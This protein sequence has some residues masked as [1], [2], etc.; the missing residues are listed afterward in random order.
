MGFK[1]DTSFLRFLTMGALGVRRVSAELRQRGFDP[2][3]LERY[4]TSNKIWA[5]KVKRLR[6]PDLLCV[7]TGLRVEV[8]TKSDLKIRMSD[9]PNNPDRA[10]DAGCRNEDVVALIA[11][12][13][14]PNG[15]EP[16]DGAVYFSVRALRD[17]V[18][19]SK[20]GPPKSA[21][22]GAERDR[23][24]PATI[25]SRPGK[26]L[27]V[28]RDRLVVT[29]EGDG[30]PS[31]NQT[32]SL[33]D[34]HAYVRP[35]EKFAA[36]VTI[37][38]GT[39]ASLADLDGPLA[40]V[41][42]PLDEISSATA[43]DRYAAV[44]ALRFR[45]DLRQKAVVALEKR[46][47]TEQ[48][49]RVGL[50]AAASAAALGSK[51]GEEYV[52]GVL[53]GDGTAEMR[54]EAILI[55]TELKTKFAHDQLRKVASDNRFKGDER[56]QAAIWGLGKAGLKSYDELVQFIHDEEDDAA[57]HA[58]AAFNFETPRPVIEQL[59]GLVL[60]GDLRRSPA[61]AEALRV[62]ASP[63][64]L[65]CLVTAANAQTGRTEWA[66]AAIGRFPSAMVFERI[67]GTP[68]LDR[69]VPMLLLARGAN[70]LA[71][72]DIETDLGFLLKQVL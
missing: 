54:M 4:C 58:I 50:E 63:A 53:W 68:L 42:D 61:A 10:W 57:L 55:L 60:L 32:Y 38:A 66:I 17:S 5:T 71:K 23:T 19:S 26:V 47:D 62:I 28:S 25:P 44:K 16:A 13:D 30:S 49:I 45:T 70:W 67:K 11:C 1:V 33:G 41:Y 37:L 35:G 21:S 65:D 34:K 36:S 31:R 14:G 52:A 24:W 8:R 46:L 39:P 15:P 72:E 59:V 6:L 56:R 29:M 27:T 43:I 51:K 7:R 3:E 2:I 9:A 12:S 22:E 64:A 69:V 40:Q 48:E 20:L 18:G